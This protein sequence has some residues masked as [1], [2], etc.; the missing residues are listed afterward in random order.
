MCTQFQLGSISCHFPCSLARGR[1]TDLPQSQRISHSYVIVLNPM[2]DKS[3][4]KASV[5]LP[6]GPLSPRSQCPSDRMRCQSVSCRNRV[7]RSRFTNNPLR[8]SSRSD[9]LHPSVTQFQRAVS[10]RLHGSVHSSPPVPPLPACTTAVTS[11]QRRGR[12]F[13][14]VQAPSRV[15]K[16]RVPSAC[17]YSNPIPR[18]LSR[19]G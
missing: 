2:K 6:R 15:G 10:V 19:S 12:S 16:S 3:S 18:R 7:I 13:P 9:P 17:V 8:I 4:L 1:D 5:L 14:L 11:L